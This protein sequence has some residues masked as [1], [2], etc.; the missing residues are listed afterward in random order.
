MSAIRFDPGQIVMTPGAAE[1]LQRAGQLPSEFILRHIKLEQGELKA[2]DHRENASAMKCGLR[3]FSSFKTSAGDILWVISEF[4]DM[5]NGG[6][7]EKRDLTTILLPGD[8]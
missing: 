8:Y 5:K 4:V 6:R 3:V 7:P 2:G 1:A